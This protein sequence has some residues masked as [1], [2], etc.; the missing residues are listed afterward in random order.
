MA[1]RGALH[2]EGDLPFEAQ[3]V[4]REALEAAAGKEDQEVAAYVQ[5]RSVAHWR[6]STFRR[7][8]WM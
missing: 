4:V 6:G 2:F 1:S 7:A 3:G 8:Y 5:V